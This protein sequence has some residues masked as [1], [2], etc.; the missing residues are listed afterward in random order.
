MG[1]FIFGQ[2]FGKAANRRPPRLSQIFG[3]R[4]LFARRCG[5]S[6]TARRWQL[7]SPQGQP[8]S[9]DSVNQG[10]REVHSQAV[11]LI[12]AQGHPEPARGMQQAVKD[13]ALKRRFQ[14][15][16]RTLAF[17]A[18]LKEALVRKPRPSDTFPATGP[19]FAPGTPA[20]ST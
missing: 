3:W 19:L 5:G 10:A 16:S 12:L 18:A 8:E 11:A 17:T 1:T 13:L 9:A 15:R 2:I 7:F 20:S 14:V 6:S 4:P